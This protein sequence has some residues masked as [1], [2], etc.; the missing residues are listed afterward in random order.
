MAFELS[1]NLIARFCRMWF[2]SFLKICFSCKNIFYTWQCKNCTGGFV[3]NRLKMVVP[4]KIFIK[5]TPKLKIF[6]FTSNFYSIYIFIIYMISLRYVIFTSSFFLFE[7]NIPG[8]IFHSF[9][10]S[11]V[12]YFTVSEY[13]WFNILQF[14]NIFGSIFYCF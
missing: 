13:P 3:C 4:V 9:W 11:F 12:Q 7:E 14:L 5:R 6:I 2:F 8:L 1:I 10:I